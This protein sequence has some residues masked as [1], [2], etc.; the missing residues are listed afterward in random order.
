MPTNEELTR[1]LAH[2]VNRPAFFRV[3]SAVLRTA[4]GEMAPELLNSVNAYPGA[5]LASGFTF[6]DP[7]VSAVIREGLD[8]I[9][10]T[11][12]TRQSRPAVGRST[13]AQGRATAGQ[14]RR[15]DPA[16]DTSPP[17][18][19]SKTRRVIRRGVVR[20]APD[21]EHLRLQPSYDEPAG[22][23]GPEQPDIGSTGGRARYV[24]R[25]AAPRVRRGPG[26]RSR[27][28]SQSWSTSRPT[29]RV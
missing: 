18:T 29:W 3:P 23:I 22:R 17:A 5:L 21:G 10:L 27:R 4:A 9:A 14:S 25:A 6:R 20:S 2:Q 26:P 1:E 15:R 28:A 13:S 24:E 8:P 16:V 7:D 11:S 19:R 12:V